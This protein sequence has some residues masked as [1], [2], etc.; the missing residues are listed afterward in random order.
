M[1]SI[2][3]PHWARDGG[4]TN[5]DEGILCRHHH[6]LCHNNGWEIE[7]SGG[8]WW[9]VPP[10]EIHPDQARIGMPT[11]SGALRDLLREAT[12]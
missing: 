5:I 7:A 8:E 2:P 9:L 11:K 3:A 12:G 4:G 6:L 10:P 1:T